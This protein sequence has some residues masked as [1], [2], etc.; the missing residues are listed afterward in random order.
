MPTLLRL[1][2]TEDKKRAAALLV[3]A[4]VVGNPGKKVPAA[5]R[6]AVAAVWEGEGNAKDSGEV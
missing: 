4:R 3:G 1:A 5:P 6:A 2:A